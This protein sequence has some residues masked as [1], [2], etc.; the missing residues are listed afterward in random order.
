M[1]S[2]LKQFININYIL[3]I[4]LIYSFVSIFFILYYLVID[5]IEKFESKIVVQKLTNIKVPLEQAV[6][7]SNTF[8]KKYVEYVLSFIEFNKKKTT[9]T[10]KDIQSIIAEK[11]KYT[12]QEYFKIKLNKA[13]I[14]LDVYKFFSIFFLTYLF[15]IILI[16]ICLSFFFYVKLFIFIDRVNYTIFYFFLSIYMSHYFIFMLK[17]FKILTFISIFFAVLIYLFF[18]FKDHKIKSI[19]EFN[20]QNEE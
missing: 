2:T 6:K 19:I 14:F 1:K 12:S 5:G 13:N 8:N 4:F 3:E 15:I 17:K 20:K 7:I 10:N 16:I 9:L 18:K 11:F